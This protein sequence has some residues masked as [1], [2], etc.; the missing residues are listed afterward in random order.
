MTRFIHVATSLVGGA[1]V[2]AR[3]LHTSMVTMG[4]DSRILTFSDSGKDYNIIQ[5]RRNFFENFISK[6]LT[7]FQMNLSKYSFF[8]L[9]SLSNRNLIVFCSSENFSDDVLVVHNS[10]NLVSLTDLVKISKNFKRVIVIQHDMRW[11]TGGCHSPVNCNNFVSGCSACP[12]LPRMISSIPHMIFK[13]ETKLIGHMVDK[14]LFISPSEFLASAIKDSIKFTKPSVF[15]GTNQL[16]NIFLEK[17]GGKDSGEVTLGV[18]THGKLSLLKGD[19]V[20]QEI[21]LRLLQGGMSTGIKILEARNMA[22]SPNRM[23]DFYSS[24]DVL[25]VLSRMDN[26]PNVVHEAH[27]LGIPVIATKVG[28]ITELLDYRYD[29]GLDIQTLSADFVLSG[30]DLYISRL[31]KIEDLTDLISTSYREKLSESQLLVIERL[32]N[33]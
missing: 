30:L 32:A 9:I 16:T 11:I 25:L 13:R 8:S 29:W 21:K 23:H 1:G 19:D 24:I 5:Q 14:L 20:V 15:V 6:V 4:W 17:N 10:Y 26:S 7:L 3:N 22:D 2:A 28:G 18:A 33:E 12:L 31:R 27:S